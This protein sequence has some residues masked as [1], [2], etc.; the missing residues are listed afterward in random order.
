MKINEMKAR[1]N[2]PK[3]LVLILLLFIFSFCIVL[4]AAYW[5]SMFISFSMQTMEY[6]IER[7]LNMTAERLAELVSAKELDQYRDP[8][9]IEL[10]AYQHLRMKLVDFSERM[11]ILYAYF[12]RDRGEDIIYIIDN[13]FDEKTRVGLDTPPFYIED[14]PNVGIALEGK[15]VHTGLGNYSYGWEGL[16]TSYAPVF[17][18]D[19]TIAAI[20]G[21]DID[22]EANVR[23]RDIVKILTAVQIIVVVIVFV[24]GL[25]SFILFRGEAHAAG[26]A[27]V[28][29]SY[30]LANMSHEIR[31]PMNAIIGMTQI[32][33]NS[34]DMEKKVYAFEKI[35]EASNHLLSVINDVLDM[36]K[37]EAGKL[38]LNYAELDLKKMIQKVINVFSFRIEE[39]K[40]S[41]SLHLDENIPKILIGDEQHLIQVITNLLSNA[42]K[43]TPEYGSIWLKAN[44]IGEKKGVCEIKIEVKDTGIGIDQE[45]QIHLF[46]SFEQAENNT[47]RTFGGTGLGLAICK[48]IV[49]LMN[50]KIW[51]E[52][53]AGK[54]AS[55]IFTIPLEGCDKTMTANDCVIDENG[56]CK[57]TVAQNEL[58]SF[59]GYKILLAEDVEINR[60][61]VIALL[62]PTEIEIECVVNGADAVKTFC[63]APDCYDL[64]FMD[65]QM[66]QM[67]GLEAAKKIRA[68]E[69]EHNTV[70]KSV[71]IIAMT[72]NVFKEDI[73]K[74]LEAGMNAHVG[75]PLDLNEV[76]DI[77]KKFLCN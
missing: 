8:A 44:L 62:E 50:G 27:S 37:I 53:E 60:E 16:L 76:T 31:T 72:A 2:P 68:F 42:I 38:D 24:S 14:E 36:S 46:N 6:S 29:K 32:G 77:L 64:I 22:D 65:I 61:I 70:K 67:D 73:D 63:S 47:S 45:N 18:A 21:V 54:G 33:K 1:K 15:I 49:E 13:D 23:A 71:P 11:D 35:E 75:K 40:H 3:H 48:R 39:K 20:A 17:R 43:F 34:P 4:F 10:P 9:D 25:V 51:V 41:F 66:P 74:C 55:F 69:A 19:G 12:L 30:F 57:D 28:A 7:R 52:S 59:R 56:I 26:Q 5:T 58:P